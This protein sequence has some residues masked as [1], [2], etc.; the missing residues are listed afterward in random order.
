MIYSNTTTFSSR[1]KLS[2]VGLFYFVQAA[3]QKF[4]LP[5]HN[6]QDHVEA[7]GHPRDF[8]GN[9]RNSP[10]NFQDSLGWTLFRIVLDTHPLT[11]YYSSEY[12][13]YCST[14]IYITHFY[15]DIRIPSW[16]ASILVPN[17]STILLYF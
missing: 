14:P 17:K 3:H 4:I 6:I 7:P 11:P 12:Y 10:V 16:S 5:L 15:R 2:I 13:A 8:W 9:S 1:A